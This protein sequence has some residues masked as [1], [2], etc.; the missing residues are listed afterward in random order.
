MEMGMLKVSYFESK[1]GNLNTG[2][3]GFPQVNPHRR[4]VQGLLAT[5]AQDRLCDSVCGIHRQTFKSIFRYPYDGDL[6]IQGFVKVGAQT[7]LAIGI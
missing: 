6:L 2:L 7:R 3:L 1:L 5:T 4:D